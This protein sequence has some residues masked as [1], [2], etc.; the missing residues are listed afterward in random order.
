MERKITLISGGQTGCDR[1]VV[2]FAIKNS[3]PYQ[4]Y[5]PCGRLAED[6]KIPL[7][8]EN[9][10][11]GDSGHYSERTYRNILEADAVLVFHQGVP[12]HGTQLTLTLAGISGKPCVDIDLSQEVDLNQVQE[13]LKNHPR[14]NIAGPRESQSPG[15]YQKVYEVLKKCLVIG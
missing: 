8:Y 9:F 10:K 11:E 13:F 5:I 12:D 14:L 15:I 6:G 2:D 4:G 1:A 3:I 7:C